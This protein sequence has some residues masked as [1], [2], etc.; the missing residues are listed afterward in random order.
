MECTE[1]EIENFLVRRVR[2]LK[3]VARKWVSPGWG[4][5]PD[6]IVLLPGGKIAFV[7]LKKPAG[8]P[9]LLQLKRAKELEALGFK[10]FCGVN[11]KAAVENML[12]E[13][14]Q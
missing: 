6:R 13:I 3:G 12:E 2:A 10:V 8:L 7:E 1:R 11:S 5:A 4:G 14:S 9:R